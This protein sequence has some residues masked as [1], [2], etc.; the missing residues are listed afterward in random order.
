M[1]RRY[2][3]KLIFPLTLL[4]L[5]FQVS[6][7]FDH[8][9]LFKNM[10]ASKQASMDRAYNTDS[11]TRA[12]RYTGIPEQEL[13]SRFA[14]ALKEMGVDVLSDSLYVF[15]TFEMPEK[16]IKETLR[17]AMASGATVVIKGMPADANSL[18]EFLARYLKAFRSDK[19]YNPNL[20]IDPRLFDVYDITVAPTILWTKEATKDVCQEQEIKSTPYRGRHFNL[21]T[22]VKSDDYIKISGAVTM[23]YALDMF[24]EEG[25]DVQARIDSLNKWYALSEKSR[26]EL[27]RETWKDWGDVREEDGA[28]VPHLFDTPEPPFVNIIR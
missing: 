26:Q 13:A 1:L 18:D 28:I 12:Q 5:S 23:S 24:L 15:I 14:K 17:D 6:A 11:L 21:R 3:K 20:Q 7:E 25:V 19:G 10:K 8:D 4:S 22:C 16:L 2:L 27:V 9:V